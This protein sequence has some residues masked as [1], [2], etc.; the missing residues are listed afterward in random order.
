MPETT[1]RRG[2]RKPDRPIIEPVYLETMTEEQEL[3]LARCIVE[4]SLAVERMKRE[5]KERAEQDQGPAPGREL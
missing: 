4:M 1:K 2:G 5:A 3:N